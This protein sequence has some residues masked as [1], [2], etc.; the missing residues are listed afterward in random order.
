MSL[1]RSN[2]VIMLL[3]WRTDKWSPVTIQQVVRNM[4]NDVFTKRARHHTTPPYLGQGTTTTALLLDQLSYELTPDIVRLLINFL[5]SLLLLGSDLIQWFCQ[6]INTKCTLEEMIHFYEKFEEFKTMHSLAGGVW[7]GSGG[8]MDDQEP[9]Q[10][11]SEQMLVRNPPPAVPA[12]THW[13]SS[14]EKKLDFWTP[15]LHFLING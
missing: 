1:I 15:E 11:L 5:R 8:L 4:T 10:V 7:S 12:P 2:E 6:I 3:Q 14:R 13:I 9:D